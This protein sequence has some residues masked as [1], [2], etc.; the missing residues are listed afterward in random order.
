VFGASEALPHPHARPGAYAVIRVIDTGT[1]IAPEIRERIFEPFFTTKP[2][3][4]GTG[5]GL[6]TVY[7]IVQQ[8]GGFITVESELGRGATF[9]GLPAASA[10]AGS[11]RRR[12]SRVPNPPPTP[13]GS[14]RPP[15]SSRQSC[16]WRMTPACGRSCWR[17]CGKRAIGC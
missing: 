11:D 17:C 7:G 15:P 9:P 3:G 4:Q 10:N 13:A 6:A 5:L 8:S 12:P 1:G 16:W 2:E 14:L